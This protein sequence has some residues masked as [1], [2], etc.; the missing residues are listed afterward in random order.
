MPIRRTQTW[1]YNPTEGWLAQS[2]LF[3]IGAGMKRLVFLV[4][5][6]SLVLAACS[7]SG[8]RSDA[9]TLTV[10]AAASLTDAFTEMGKSFEASHPGVTIAFNFG[11]SQNLRTQIQQGAVVDVFASANAKEMD[12]L[13]SENLVRAGTPKVFL[14]NRLTVI[15]PKDNPAGIKSLDD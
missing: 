5:L 9:H 11:G 2:P 12:S 15:L 6:L 8:A 13:V 14:T 7:G 4:V 10:Y 1:A 3:F